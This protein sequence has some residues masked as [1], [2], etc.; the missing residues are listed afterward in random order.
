MEASFIWRDKDFTNSLSDLA[1]AEFV[2]KCNQKIENGMISCTG[3]VLINRAWVRDQVM[4][5]SYRSR[6]A[7]TGDCNAF[8]H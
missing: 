1:A 8:A 3:S 5:A 6:G 2:Y 7:C 4:L